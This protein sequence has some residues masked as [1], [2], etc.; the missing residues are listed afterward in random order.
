MSHIKRNNHYGAGSVS[1]TTSDGQQ[2]RRLAISSAAL[3]T[4]P[5]EGVETVADVI[6]YAA[7]THGSHPAWGWRDVVKIHTEE[8]DIKKMVDG[9]QITEKKKWNYF[10]LS[11]YKYITF[12]DI[13]ERVSEVARGLISLGVTKEEIVNVYAATA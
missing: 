1:V 5:V 7:R 12:L 6:S 2:A 3:V 9:E 11:D 13:Q 8:K 4:Q 10:E